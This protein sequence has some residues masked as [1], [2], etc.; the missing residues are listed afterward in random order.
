M[1]DASVQGEYSGTDARVGTYLIRSNAQLA[2]FVLH[3][4]VDGVAKGI[5]LSFIFGSLI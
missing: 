2:D 1:T 3:G 4:M 5:L